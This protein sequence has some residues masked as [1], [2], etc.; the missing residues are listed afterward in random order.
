MTAAEKESNLS[1][2]GYQTNDYIAMGCNLSTPA[3]QD[4]NVRQA[5]SYALDRQ[6]LINVVFNGQAQVSTMSQ[7]SRVN[8]SVPTTGMAT[9]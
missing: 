3:L 7:G 5:M 2:L 9:E 4:Q 8:S 1:V 6:T